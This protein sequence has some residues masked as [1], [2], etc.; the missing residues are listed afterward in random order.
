MIRRLGRS[1]EPSPQAGTQLLGDRDVSRVA[2][3]GDQMDRP[4]TEVLP[5]SQPQRTIP[6]MHAHVIDIELDPAD[7]ARFS[8]L[9]NDAPEV[10]VIDV[11]QSQPD[12]WTVRIGCASDDVAHRLRAAW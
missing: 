12:V 6:A 7:F 11:D 2:T 1:A 9:T 4:P 5:I 8:C 10:R 3:G